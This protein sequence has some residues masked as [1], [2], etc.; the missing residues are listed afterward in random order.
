MIRTESWLVATPGGDGQLEVALPTDPLAVL[1]LGHGAGGG[2]EAFDLVSLAEHLPARNI[3]VA[4]F[5][6]PWRVAG[7]RVAGPPKHL[8]EAWR[9]AVAMVLNRCGDT[10]LYVGGH[11]AGARVACRCFA[12]P[13]NGLVALSFPLHPP[14][15]PERSRA[16][17]L[18][19]VPAPVL[20]VQ[21]SKDPFGNPE[22]LTAAFRSRPDVTLRVIEDATHS[23]SPTRK[24][25]DAA[26]R[27]TEI[28]DAVAAF[29]GGLTAR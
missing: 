13:A 27:A 15:K 16:E 21:G 23:F 9:P 2:I 18:L 22:E 17:E 11:S 29:I 10:P 7:R 24:S 6:Q 25:Q 19:G 4:R 8:D 20:I 12:A 28:S 5:V 14:G 26:G 3:A 1:L